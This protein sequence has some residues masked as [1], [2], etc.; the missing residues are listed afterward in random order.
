MVTR[1]SIPSHISRAL[2][3]NEKKVQK[4]DAE[5]L[6]ASG[7]L[8]S[9]E[10]LNFHEKLERFTDL[11][12]LNKAKTN[13]LH[14]SLNFDNAD[15]LDKEKLIQIANEY[16]DRMGLGN[17]PYLTYQHFD[18]AHPHI[19]IVTT[20]IEPNGERIP[21][22]NIGKVSSE[23][24]RREIEIGYGLVIADAKK[25]KD[26]Y[27]LKPINAQKIAYGKSAT[28]QAITQVL[29][30]IINRYKY[31]SLA[32]LNAI[33]SLYNVK[34]DRGSE[35]SRTHQNNGLVY[36]VLNENGDPIGVPIK[37]SL[38]YNNPGLKKIEAIGKKNQ[39]ERLPYKR[40]MKN[41]IDLAILRTANP[42]LQNVAAALKKN[43]IEMIL[44]R[45]MDGIIYG[46]TYVD[47]EKRTVFNG[48]SLGPQYSAKGMQER[49]VEK[50]KQQSISDKKESV[51]SVST[52]GTRNASSTEG[53]D[54]LLP[55]Q[56]QKQGPS[57][58]EILTQQQQLDTID[59]YLKRNPKKK[60]RKKKGL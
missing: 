4:G 60:K 37:A 59:T 3:Y 14:I 30:E 17:Q 42:S 11:M 46:I 29:D 58:L 25:E 16:M 40:R 24:V 2:N 49:C 12:A 1:I 45:N 50:S 9:P 31:T 57:L 54:Y 27:T 39:K 13:S 34:A 26:A 6:S 5:L 43:G 51:V 47:F 28:R 55:M 33:L 36:R 8:K 35:R 44:R 48:S 53:N 32:E 7:Y 10:A 20:L 38:I 23:K 21:T 19:H 52:T 18:A 15:V 41:A 22:H 56:E